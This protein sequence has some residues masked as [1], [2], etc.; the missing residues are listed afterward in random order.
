MKKLILLF[1]TIL[2]LAA[3]P[4]VGSDSSESSNCLQIKKREYIN[5]NITYLIVKSENKNNIEY[6][7]LNKLA[8][9]NNAI[10]FFESKPIDF[11]NSK[12]QHILL[13]SFGSG[14]NI[15][16][17]HTESINYLEAINA[18]VS[19]TGNIQPGVNFRIQTESNIAKLNSNVN[20]I[21]G[22]TYFKQYGKSGEEETPI[23][24]Y[25]MIKY[26]K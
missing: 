24:L 3:Y 21:S 17:S 13:H 20:L 6:N 23:S 9:G 14:N 10:S 2:P 11:S 7:F 22:L 5:Y 25:N 12:T 19:Y 16:I 15:N 4:C 8:N 18:G 26:D 1:A